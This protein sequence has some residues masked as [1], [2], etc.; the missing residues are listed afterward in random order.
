[1]TATAVQ[2][3]TARKFAA[4]E[5]PT[6]ASSNDIRATFLDYFARNGDDNQWG[7]TAGC[8]ARGNCTTWGDQR[9]MLAFTPSRLIGRWSRYLAFTFSFIQ[10]EEGCA[11]LLIMMG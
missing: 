3:S 8:E 10:D 11:I 9:T 2:I 7:G 4:S 6:M 1:M 5:K